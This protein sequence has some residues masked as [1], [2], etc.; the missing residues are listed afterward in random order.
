LGNFKSYST[1]VMKVFAS[2]IIPQ[3]GIQ[4]L[5]EAGCDVDEY[6]GKTHPSQEELIA[7]CK[8]YDGLISAGPNRLDRYFFEQCAHLKAIALYSV[9]YDNV[10]VQA[11]KD[12]GVPVGNTPGVLSNSTADVA[13][14][15]MLAVSRKAIF[16]H[17]RIVRGDWGFYEPTAHLGIELDKKTLGIVGLGRI[18][19]EMARK[20]VGAYNMEVI[21]HNRTRNLEAESVFGAR[22]VSFE[23]LLNQSDVIS[24]HSNL[25]DQTRGL[26]D[27]N[28]F[29][30]MK[31]KSIFINTARGSIHNEVDLLKALQEGLIWGA[32]LD[33]TN[34]EPMDKKHPLLSMP[35]VCVLPHIGS[36]TEE[37]RDA[38]AV[39]TAQNILAGLRGEPMPHAIV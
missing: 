17:N 29:A 14:L 10:D 21:Y 28:A 30:K 20:C 16:M 1:K 26:F 3:K 12:H 27:Y 7:I 35:N 36:A 11:A 31:Q 24:V 18:G 37:T 19:F 33:V 5:K 9:G 22:W 25:S 2:R 23:E 15:L 39:I 6:G 32:G 4:L 38:M 13:F 8:Q 34:P